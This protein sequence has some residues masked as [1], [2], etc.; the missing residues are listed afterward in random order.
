MMRE[1]KNGKFEKKKLPEQ[2]QS[3]HVPQTIKERA[4]G[5]TI[6][7][8]GANGGARRG[9]GGRGSEGDQGTIQ[10]RFQLLMAFP[11]HFPLCRPSWGARRAEMHDLDRPIASREHEA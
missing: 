4:D 7:I 3:R 11:M 10:R 5:G 9:A 1:K 8:A 6:A 2:G